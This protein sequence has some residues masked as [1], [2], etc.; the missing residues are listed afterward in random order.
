MLLIKVL[1]DARSFDYK[2]YKD[3]PDGFNNN[4]KNNSIDQLSLLDGSRVI[5]CCR[6]QSVANYCF[7]KERPG[8]TVSYGDSIAPG[9]FA[10]RCFVSP[11]MFHGQPH[12]IINAGDIDGQSIDNSAMQ[13]TK[14]GYQNGRW[15]IH[16]KCNV[17]TGKDT[18][19]AWS[20]GCII[21]SSGDLAEL[22]VSLSATGVRAGDVI[23][24]LMA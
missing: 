14:N 16:D 9:R 12:A 18:N 20:A 7:G 15:L 21:L 2:V 19:Y 24:G 23:Y 11:R 13:V 6:C 1:R 5:F 17:A 22:G 4:Y 3:R 8:D 10:V